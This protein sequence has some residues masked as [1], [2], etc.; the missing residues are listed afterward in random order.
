MTGKLASGQLMFSLS[1]F[2]ANTFENCATMENM[3]E[4]MQA[5]Y[6]AWFN[7]TLVKR[8]NRTS[9]FGIVNE[10]L[11]PGIVA[12]YKDNTDHSITF[13]VHFPE[14]TSFSSA[15]IAPSTQCTLHTLHP[16]HILMP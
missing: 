7:D 11:L 15:H 10:Q 5:I 2:A 1:A 12:R 9:G 13:D 16:A 14:G 6:G 4:A 3:G 8:L